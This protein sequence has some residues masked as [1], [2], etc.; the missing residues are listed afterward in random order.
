MLHY[1]QELPGQWSGKQVYSLPLVAI[2]TAFGPGGGKTLIN[3]PTRLG[4]CEQWGERGS[5]RQ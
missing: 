1:G 5:T 2:E 3:G 4:L